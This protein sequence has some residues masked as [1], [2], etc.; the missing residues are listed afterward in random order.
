L[1]R[2]Q[3]IEILGQVIEIVKDKSTA[4]TGVHCC[5]NTDWS[6]LLQLGVD[7]LSFD[8]YG[9]GQHFVVYPKEV[10][11][12]L[13]R[14]SV[15]AWGFIPTAEYRATLGVEDV[16]KKAVACFEALIEKG[17]SKD[18]LVRQSMITPACGTGLM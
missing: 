11:A 18:V 13:D 12:F 14:G 16:R 1:E 2:T 10:G 17:I 3:V 5:G 9:F 6:L 15:I 7:I 4:K 8:A